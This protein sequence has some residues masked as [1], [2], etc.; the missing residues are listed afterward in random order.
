AS[1]PPLNKGKSLGL[2]SLSIS[3]GFWTTRLQPSHPP[4]P[5]GPSNLAFAAPQRRA[6]HSAAFPSPLSASLTET[7]PPPSQSAKTTSCYPL[8]TPQ[9]PRKPSRTPALAHPSLAPAPRRSR[10]FAKPARSGAA[11]RR[12]GPRPAPV[13]PIP[14]PRP[15]ARSRIAA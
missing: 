10:C 5:I 14:D 15:A 2:S 7:L 13:P 12:A 1:C 9:T 3:S 4:P 11:H 6:Q 8:E